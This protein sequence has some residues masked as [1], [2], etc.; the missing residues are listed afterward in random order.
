MTGSK[1]S[2]RRPAHEELRLRRGEISSR[3]LSDTTGV[4]MSTLDAWTKSGW[5]TVARRVDG[6]GK[7]SRRIFN[8]AVA[9]DEV[10]L[11]VQVLEACPYNH[12]TQ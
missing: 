7:G 10:D 8:E 2:G 9:V 3:Q 1:N 5:V 12:K 11:V 4:S 6:K